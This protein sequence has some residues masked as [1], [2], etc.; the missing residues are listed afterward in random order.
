MYHTEPESIQLIQNVVYTGI[1][2]I[3]G[4]IKILNLTEEKS[5]SE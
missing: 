5:S 3:T 2:R 4:E 1:L